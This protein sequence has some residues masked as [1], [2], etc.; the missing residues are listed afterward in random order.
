[1]H[2]SGRPLGGPSCTPNRGPSAL[3]GSILRVRGQARASGPQPTQSSLH[4]ARLEASSLRSSFLHSCHHLL[5]L[6]H[7][8]NMLWLKL[9]VREPIPG[10]GP[11]P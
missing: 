1:M 11:R 5:Y 4:A 8:P 7:F 10:I 9:A 2:A 6:C 3:D